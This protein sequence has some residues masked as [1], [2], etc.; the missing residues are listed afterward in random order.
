M[1]EVVLDRLGLTRKRGRVDRASG[2]FERGQSACVRRRTFGQIR[3]Q[4][5]H[6]RSSVRE[7]GAGE[8]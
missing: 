5:A 3:R 7:C 8:R 2:P 1:P 6:Q 4:R